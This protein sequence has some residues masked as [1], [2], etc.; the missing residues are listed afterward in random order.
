[1]KTEKR[2]FDFEELLNHSLEAAKRSLE[3]TRLKLE[4][5]RNAT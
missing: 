4:A 1:M 3:N 5:M 2:I